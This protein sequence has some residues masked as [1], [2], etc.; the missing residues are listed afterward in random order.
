MSQKLPSLLQILLFA[1]CALISICAAYPYL[2]LAEPNYSTS[3]H[4]VK[5]AFD[6]FDNSGVFS[7]GA[8]RLDRL[9]DL[10]NE[11]EDRK[12]RAFDRL[13]NADFGLRRKRSFDR[14]GGTEFG[15]MKRS[16]GRV[17]DRDQLIEN[18]ADSIAA[19]RQARSIENLGPLL[20]TYNK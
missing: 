6:R 12:K 18:L 7:F 4:L 1:Q 10:E 13:D 16:A 2:V 14:M 3:R 9:D 20:V 5:R 19:L 11:Y 15:L 17:S 8:K